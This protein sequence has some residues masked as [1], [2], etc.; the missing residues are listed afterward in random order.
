MNEYQKAG[1]DFM[2]A[3]LLQNT[4][5]SNAKQRGKII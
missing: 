3:E 1:K 4:N 2:F 5:K